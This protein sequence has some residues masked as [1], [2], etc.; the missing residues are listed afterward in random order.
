[1]PNW[2]SCRLE[3]PA[4][5][6]KKYIGK[7]ED[8]CRIFDFNLV[9]P[10]PEIY[11]DPDLVSGGHQ[12]AAIYWFRS[13]RGTKEIESIEIKNKNSPIYEKILFDRI[14]GVFWSDKYPVEIH[15][16]PD[17]LYEIGRKYIE[18]YNKYGFLDW[19]DWSC[20][21]WG[22]KWNAC[23]STFDDMNDE[24][25]WVSFDTA[26]CFPEPIVKKIFD[27]NPGCEITFEWYD[28]DYDG[29]HW[30]IRRDDGTIEEGCE[31]NEHH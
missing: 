8:G 5:V 31:Y 24:P 22:T 12:D 16:D 7:D 21:K 9:I 10:R 23:D 26:W 11:E 2:T 14:N 1:M 25:E 27:D 29:D 17:K 6:L 19:Y 4:D 15:G 3:A 30:L 13:E 18:A 20:A 28:E